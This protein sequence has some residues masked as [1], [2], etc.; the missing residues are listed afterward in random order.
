M[1]KMDE[2]VEGVKEMTAELFREQRELVARL[3]DMQ[4]RIEAEAH[5][6]R[7]V[8]RKVEWMEEKERSVERL[9]KAVAS[10]QGAL[11]VDAASEE[12]AAA[13]INEGALASAPS[14]PWTFAK[15]CNDPQVERRVD[16]EPPPPPADSRL[17]AST[18]ASLT[19]QRPGGEEETL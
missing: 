15:A 17:T 7:K 5:P 14:R 10:L 9:N 11:E 16:P 18:P 19:L 13:A 6:V 4:Q 3:N 12:M 2:C 1:C 8:L